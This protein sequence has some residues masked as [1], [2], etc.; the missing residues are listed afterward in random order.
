MEGSVGWGKDT[1]NCSVVEFDS[2]TN[3]LKVGP[4]QICAT[5]KTEEMFT[6]LSAVA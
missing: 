3:E 4:M 5:D 2:V 6:R 1:P